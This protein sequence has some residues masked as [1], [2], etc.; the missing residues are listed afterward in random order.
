MISIQ[1]TVR[2]EQMEYITALSTALRQC[3]SKLFHFS[4]PFILMQEIKMWFHQIFHCVLKFVILKKCES[5]RVNKK[6]RQII[7][8]WLKLFFFVPV[9][10]LTISL[11]K[12]FFII[13]DM[14]FLWTDSECFSSASPLLLF[15][16][17][18]FLTI[19][20]I[21]NIH[22]EK[23]QTNMRKDLQLT[24]AIYGCP[25]CTTNYSKFV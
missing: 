4:S 20:I 19:L 21:F 17:S 23:F 18:T 5:L 9:F 8:V 22:Q 6:G 3:R 14:I 1:H 7:R 12:D 24:A 25:L 10:F 15:R 16:S 2:I 13:F 11:S